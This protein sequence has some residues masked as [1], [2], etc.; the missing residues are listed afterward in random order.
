MCGIIGEHD[1]KLREIPGGVLAI[2][3][4]RHNTATRT[5][6]GRPDAQESESASQASVARACW[7]SAR[8]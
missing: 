4:I 7:I 5:E 2:N 3:I 8:C 6:I 1:T